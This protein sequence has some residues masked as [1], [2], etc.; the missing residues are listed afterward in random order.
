MVDLAIGALPGAALLV[1]GLGAGHLHLTPLLTR[2]AFTPAS[3]Q[4]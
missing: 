2:V 1:G 4:F 3:V